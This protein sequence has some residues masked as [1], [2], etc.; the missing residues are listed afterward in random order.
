MK[1]F[2]GCKYSL[3]PLIILCFI[4]TISCTTPNVTKNT[5]EITKVGEAPNTNTLSYTGLGAQKNVSGSMHSLKIGGNN[6]MIDAGIFYGDEGKNYPWPDEIDP[7]NL[8]AVF[9]THAHA[10]HIG[11]LPLLLKEGYSGPIYMTKVTYDLVKIMLVSSIKYFDFGEEP[12]Y[13]SRNNKSEVKPVY[14]EEYYYGDREV[15]VKNRV[16]IKSQRADLNDKGFYMSDLLLEH[17]EDELLKRLEEQVKVIEYDKPFKVDNI[18]AEFLYTTH[19][20]GSAMLLLNINGKNILFSGDLGSDNSPFLKKNTPLDIK[21]D[22]LF[23]E[24]T[25]GINGNNSNNEAEREKFQQIIGDKLK[26]GYRIIIPAFVLDRT[27][28]VLYEISQGMENNYIPKETVV[29]AYSPTSVQITDLYKNYSSQNGDYKAFFSENMFSNL[30]N[31][32]NLIYNLK[33]S[34]GSYATNINYG[35]IAVMSSG[36]ASSAF[37]EDAINSYIEDPKTFIM[38]VGYQAEDTVG[39]DMI[40][41]SEKDESYIMIDEVEKKIDPANI[42][43]SHAFNSHADLNQIINIFKNTSPKKIF[44]VHLNEETASAIAEKYKQGFVNS[45]IIIPSYGVKY[46]LQ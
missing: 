30:F 7:T 16:I 10:D 8:K 44:L 38:I 9:I 46:D 45:E 27:Q 1:P 39:G 40:K 29:K 4:L 11:R 5:S 17:L 20:P 14:L 3:I 18:T 35:E 2:K 13:Y 32:Q 24:G 26:E 19:I 36:M 37:S 34:D 22:Y 33:N 12:F 15:M 25:Y 43:R 41:A 23:V 42:Y 21:I 31:I 28:Q 6:Y